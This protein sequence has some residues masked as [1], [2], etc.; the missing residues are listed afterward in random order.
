MSEEI[1]PFTISVN[2]DQISDLNA[3]LSATRWPDQIPDSGWDYGCDQVWLKDLARYWA[4]E[5]DWRATEN[6]IN[7]FDHFLTEIDNQ[8]FHFIHQKSPHE[9][10]L[11]LVLNHGWPGSVV[12]F[13]EVIRPLTNP[14]VYGGDP[15]DA[16]HVVAPSLP[17]YG[18]SK[19]PTEKGW[20]VNRTAS[21]FVTLMNRLGYDKY[22]VQG[23]DWGS[24][25]SRHMAH[26]DPTKVVGC[27][28][29]MMAAGPAGN[30]DDFADITPQEQQ[31]FD[32][33][34]WYAAEDNGYFRIQETRPQTLGAGLND[35]PVGL[36]SWI[37]EKFYGWTDHEDDLFSV[38]DR[39]TLLANVAVYWFTETINSSTRFYF[40][41]RQPGGMTMDSLG[42][43]PLGVSAFPNELFV[44]RKRWV[45]AS[46]NVV[47]WREHEKGGHFASLEAPQIYIDDVREF[48]RGVR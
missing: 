20:G 12:E 47:F 39:D 15:S 45:E 18:W 48:F 42:D 19:P 16:F 29:N 38:V 43:V 36:L 32:R 26:L 17:G 46:H 7:S 2:E 37:G 25:V 28:V 22:G 27:H 5:F 24:M 13:L 30:E 31:H 1:H 34:S 40:E 41:N 9:G 33:S 14:E 35:S 11:P 10:A 44:A 4:E 23:G 6:Q 3:R 8:S 21:A